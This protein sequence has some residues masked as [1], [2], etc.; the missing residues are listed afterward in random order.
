MKELILGITKDL[1]RDLLDRKD[2]EQL[3]EGEIQKA[4]EDGKLTKEDIVQAFREELDE[5]WDLLP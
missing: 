3:K 4:V 1:A 5:W 2:C